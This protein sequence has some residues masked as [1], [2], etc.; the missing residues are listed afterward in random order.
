MMSQAIFWGAVLRFA[1]AVIQATPTIL[2]G[3]VV[4]GI[5]RRLLGHENTRRLFGTGTWRELPQAWC[6]G[7]LLPVCSLGV[8]PIARELRR[9]RISGGAILAFAMTAP[10]FNPLSMLYGLTLSEPFVILSFAFCT[11]LVVTIVGLIWNRLFPDTVIEEPSP[12]PVAY[13]LRRMAA[14]VVLAAREIV[15]PSL[16]FILIGL[17]GVVLLSVVLPRGSLQATMEHTN[18]YAPVAMTLVAIPAYTTPL[19]AMSQLGSM[20]QHANS[21]GA[22]FV[23]LTLG[24]GINLGLIAWV[25]RTHG[26]PRGLAWLAML[27]TVVLGLAY[28]T[29][30][31]L[32]PSEIEPA[33]HTHAFDIYCRPFDP[34]E[35]DLAPRVLAKLQED[36]QPFE[37]VGL[38]VL[39]SLVVTGLVLRGLDRRW[40]VEDWLER[41][42]ER[43]DRARSGLDITI[44]APILGVIALAG[45]VGLSVVGCY[46][47]YPSASEVFEEMTSLRAEVLTAALSGNQKHAEHFIPVWDD[48][49][50]R[51]Q[52]GVFL[53]EG[54]LSP[55]RR[56][57]AKVFRDRLEFLKHAVQENDKDEIREY[58]G[59]VSAAYGRMRRAYLSPAN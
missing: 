29:E 33:G 4:A 38:I 40:R 55:Y 53:R 42:P 1:Q 50:R 5:F 51:L 54:T 34:G 14:I 31:P 45:L 17:L 2:V 10:L 46:A 43:P 59:K 52:V 56:T 25:L 27:V 47:Y 3:L 36:P 11:V 6:L 21:V 30:K 58:V 35:R 22:A 8:I 28:A 20:F 16:G 49:T 19:A 23:L 57:K 15:G 9:A 7:M 24:A 39:A 37:R 32:F 44:P 41:L 48:W 18:P 26:V 12:P 13:G